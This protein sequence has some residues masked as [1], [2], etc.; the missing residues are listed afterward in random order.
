MPGREPV[1]L[2]SR[3]AALLGDNRQE[4]AGTWAKILR[5]GIVGA[6][7]VEVVFFAIFSDRFLTV[8]NFRLVLLQTA[9]I[10][11][12]AIPSALLLMAG[13]VDFAIGSI[14]GLCAVL[15]GKLLGTMG[16]VPALIITVLIGLAVG[17]AQGILSSP[18]GLSPIVVTLGFFTGVRG[19][20]FVV[21]EGRTA[22][23]F[24]DTFAIIGR[25]RVRWLEIP[26]PVAIAAVTVLL[27][28]I[29]LYKTRWGRYVVAIGVN[30]RAAFRAG[31]RIN[32]IPV[33]L[34]MATGAGSAV[35]A[36][37]LV[38]RL[39]AAPPLTGEGLELNVLSAVLLGGVAFG[40]GR[41][42]LVGVIA[43]VL[44]VGLLNNGLLLF[45]VAPFW[46]RVSAGAALVV[47]AGL[48]GVGRRLE[49][50]STGGLGALGRSG[51]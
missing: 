29:F 44:F 15:L 51:I 8:S 2:R 11:T 19:V 17:A 9:V 20:V 24:G 1:G 10:A 40:G 31:I 26:V 5:N 39:D 48:D 36:M 37:I 4:I 7:V 23:G 28:A 42:S 43:G 21:T 41:G 13:Y 34:Y 32:A 38:S 16:I 33:Y 45:G 50:R 46:F 3:A 30:A 14:T 27:G 18:L 25:G 6:L 35:G 12:L 49:G 22:S 47:A